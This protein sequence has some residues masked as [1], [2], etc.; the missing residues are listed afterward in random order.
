[1]I[2]GLWGDATNAMTTGNSQDFMIP[3]KQ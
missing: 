1:M 3:I 2:S